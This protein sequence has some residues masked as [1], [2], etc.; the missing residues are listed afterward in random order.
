MVL[1]VYGAVLLESI[2]PFILS[3]LITKLVINPKKFSHISFQ[4]LLAQNQINVQRQRVGSAVSDRLHGCTTSVKISPM[5][6]S[7][8]KLIIYILEYS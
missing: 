7:Q 1:A 4:L 2:L 3:P 6:H 5:C 8:L